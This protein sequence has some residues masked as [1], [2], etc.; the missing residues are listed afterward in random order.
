MNRI[1]A[2]ALFAIASLTTCTGAIAQDHVIKANIPFDFAVG[3]TSL[4]AGEYTV[5][6]P[7]RGVLELRSAD[8]SKIVT[9]MSTESYDESRIGSKLVFDR[10]GNQY[11]LHEVL[12]PTV[13]SLNL[14]V[15]KGKSEKSARSRALEAN[16]QNSENV[17]LV[18]AR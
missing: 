15:P 3:D 12:C 17:V 18:A 6:T 2:M 8:H 5:S 4:P 1:S 7:F 13:A 10:Y 11:F 16:L 14:D 9:I